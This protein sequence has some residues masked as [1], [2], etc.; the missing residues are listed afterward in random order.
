MSFG[1]PR[2]GKKEGFEIIRSCSKKGYLI[3]G[4]FD[5]LLS[6]FEH[7]YKPNKI[8]SFI[9]IR[10]FNGRSYESSGFSLE[11]L[12]DPNYYYFDPK[13][14]SVLFNRMSFQKNR[15]HKK[16]KIF[17]PNL[18]E[19]DNMSLNGYLRIYDAGNLKMIK[20]Y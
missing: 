1:K 11:K 2:F 19:S 14:P 7:N 3:L 17:D 18:S 4:G 20:T 9:D 13:N 6:Y 12:S 8:I 15:L 5:K 10:Y 16:L